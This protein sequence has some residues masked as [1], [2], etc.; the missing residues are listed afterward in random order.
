MLLNDAQQCTSVSYKDVNGEPGSCVVGC[1]Q[2]SGCGG[3]SCSCGDLNPFEYFSSSQYVGDC[4]GVAQSSQWKGACWVLGVEW[5]W[6][7][8]FSGR[9]D[10]VSW[11]WKLI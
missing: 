11:V 4:N 8:R 6:G 9:V 3:V 2:G 10:A 1:I 5:G 7:A